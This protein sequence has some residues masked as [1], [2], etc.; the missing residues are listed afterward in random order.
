MNGLLFT[1]GLGFNLDYTYNDLKGDLVIHAD[2]AQ[3][4]VR[5]DCSGC[6]SLNCEPTEVG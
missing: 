4:C 5:T 2:K 3:D 1:C 6:T